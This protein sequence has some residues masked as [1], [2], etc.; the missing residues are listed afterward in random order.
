MPASLLTPKTRDETFEHRWSGRATR[1]DLAS[2]RLPIAIPVLLEG[3]VEQSNGHHECRLVP[4]S[5][6]RSGYGW[7]HRDEGGL[8]ATSP[9]PSRSMGHCLAAPINSSSSLRG[10][11][12]AVS[13]SRVSSGS[14]VSSRSADSAVTRNRSLVTLRIDSDFD[15]DEKRPASVSWRQFLTHRPLPT[16]LSHPPRPAVARP[17]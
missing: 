13:L 7:D 5:L 6:N 11:A 17:V 9:G 14:V 1:Y 10:S 4:P 12:A 15:F 16:P 2:I 8:R 3:M